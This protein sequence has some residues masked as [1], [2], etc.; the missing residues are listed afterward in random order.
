[1][2][3]EMWNNSLGDTQA[4]SRSPQSS[5]RELDG[6]SYSNYQHK[7]PPE[8][9]P[10]YFGPTSQSHVGSSEQPLTPVS[11]DDVALGIAIDPHSD[12]IKNHLLQI[13]FKWQEYVVVLVDKRTFMVHRGTPSYW[14]SDFLEYAMLTCASRMSSSSAVRALAGD[15]FKLAR[16][17][18]LDA[19][20]QPTGAAL[21]GFLLLSEFCGPQGWDRKGW[22]FC[23]IPSSLPRRTPE[24]AS[25]PL[26]PGLT[27]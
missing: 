26:Y 10:T 11:D 6:D 8:D 24:R 9:S 2:T 7:K 25:F 19:L 5:E 3:S 27:F 15:Y 4:M 1:M 17:E 14:Y 16:N 21:Q 13:F 20:D 22:M 12:R 23:G 18:L